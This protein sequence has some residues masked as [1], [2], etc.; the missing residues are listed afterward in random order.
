MVLI[1]KDILI[2]KKKGDT[3]WNLKTF[4]DSG[5]TVK[6]KKNLLLFLKDKFHVTDKDIEILKDYLEQ[7]K[8]EVTGKESF[9]IVYD[10]TQLCNLNCRH[11]C[12]NAKFVSNPKTSLSFETTFEQVCTIIDKINN[13][14]RKKKI[15]KFFFMIGGGEPFLRPDFPDILKYASSKLGQNNIGFNTNGTIQNV[16]DLL[17]IRNSVKTIEIS[18]DGFE[19]YHNKWRDPKKKS[20][21]KN[22]FQQSFKL[23]KSIIVESNLSKLLEVSSIATKENIKFLPSF[24]HWMYQQGVNNYSIHRAMPVGRMVS[25]SSFIPDMNN[26][27]NLTLDIARLRNKNKNIKIH[28]HHSLESIYSALFLGKDIHY[29]DVIMGSGRHSIGIDWNGN[30]F[31]DPW[32][33]IAPYDQLCAGNI[34]KRG[35]SFE[36]IID[37][38]KSPIRLANDIVK[39]NVRCRQ[40]NFSC[41]GGMRING[42]AH[43]ISQN[44]RNHKISLSHLII[45]LSQIDPACPL[46]E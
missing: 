17:S 20:Y 27:F 32:C 45:G 6:T 21:F 10:I 41:I 8:K 40:C 46:Y 29:S 5:Y 42:L 39:K 7:R 36:E 9:G 12:V 15:P 26:Y 4:R 37:S 33:G 2:I 16:D 18:I 28:V 38:V 23:V 1:F 44:R 11:C 13:Y 24:A 43:F 35:S 3:M 34:L 19:E 31:F 22:P 25:V 14:I 30:V